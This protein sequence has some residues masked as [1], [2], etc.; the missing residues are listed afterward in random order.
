MA[1]PHWFADTEPE[2]LEVL[3]ERQRQ[4]TPAEKFAAV[5][6]MSEMLL[7]LSEAGVRSRYPQADDREIF[8]RTAA[9]HLDRE[10]MLRVYGWDPDVHR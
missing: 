3:L 5:L 2:A 8:L 9:C 7:G 1:A 4:M 6:R 10:T